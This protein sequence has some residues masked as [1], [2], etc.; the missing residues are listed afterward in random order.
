MRTGAITRTSST[1]ASRRFAA[2]RSRGFDL[3]RD[4][5]VR[6]ALFRVADERFDAVWAFPH[7]LLDGWSA[8]VLLGELLAIHAAL[9]ASRPPELPEPVPYRRYLHWLERQDR[10]SSGRFWENYL[11][12][13]DEI[14][15]V[16]SERR[17]A[18]GQTYE[19]ISVPW[20]SVPR[21]HAG[22]V[23]S[24]RAARSR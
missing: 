14:T 16:P 13:H 17:R 11:E 8:G 19:P 21:G 23:N 9:A 6:V 3:T 15:S 20:V 7:L 18:E 10:E 5:L 24:P 1:G 4:P 2:D 22:C 12:G